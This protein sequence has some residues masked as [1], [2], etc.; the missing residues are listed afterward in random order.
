MGSFSRGVETEIVRNKLF[1][2]QLG[3]SYKY[4]VINQ[5]PV[6]VLG[7]SMNFS[8]RCQNLAIKIESKN[9]SCAVITSLPNLRY[10]FN[11]SGQS[12]ERLCCGLIGNEGAKSALVIPKLDT[13]KA[14]KSHAA[15]VFAW[16]DN[17][18]YA[19]ALNEAIESIGAR[20]GERIGCESG[21]TLGLLDQL[22]TGFGIQ[23]SFIQISDEISNLRLIKDEEEID[24]IKRSAAALSRVYKTIPDIIEVGKTE[25]EIALEIIK[26][27]LAKKLKPLDYPLVQSGPN[28]AIP[29]SEA[30][31]RKIRRGDMIV[32]DTSATNEEGYFADFTRTFVVGKPSQKQEKVYEIVRKAQSNGVRVA[33]TGS[34][35]RSV[36]KAARSIIE[37][38]G[39]GQ[40][41]IHRTGHGIGLEVHEA[42]FIKEGNRDSLKSGMTFTIEPGI[43]LPGRFGVRIE[44]NLVIRESSTENLTKLSH[45]LIQI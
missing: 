26:Q 40:F 1:G 45:G 12:F 4:M 17:E 3:N 5:S 36:D 34:Q 35:A 28:S 22:K 18:G 39:H 38:S 11:Y 42:P 6:P 29:H 8:K 33:E 32:V 21:L 19:N 24:S 2:Q 20:H 23:S 15:N 41:F 16:T 7:R 37:Q 14:A 31:D 13:E 9:L 10:F 25:S 44:D 30:S 27:L 43:Y